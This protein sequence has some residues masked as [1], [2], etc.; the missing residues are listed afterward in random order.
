[1]F[2]KYNVGDKVVYTGQE[3]TGFWPKRNVVYTIREVEMNVAIS[4]QEIFD[5]HGDNYYYTGQFALYEPPTVPKST[6][7]FD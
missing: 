7:F 2:I 3:S 6:S 4:L 1:M 5:E